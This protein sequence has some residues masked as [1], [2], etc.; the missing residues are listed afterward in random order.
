MRI[1]ILA[2]IMLVAACAQGSISYSTGPITENTVIP[3]GSPLGVA[4][5]ENITAGASGIPANY[6]V[7]GLTVG[8]DISGGYNGGLVAYLVA[9][10]GMMVY[11]VN[12]PGVSGGNPFG[13]PGSGMDVTLQD[14]S[15]SIQSVSETAGT[16]L[17]GT[18]GA[19]GSLS[20][21]N[22]SAADGNWTLF[23]ANLSGGGANGELLNFTLDLT[24][25]PE[26]VGMALGVFGGLLTL[27][28]FLGRCWKRPEGMTD[29]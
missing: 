26:P 13:A 18:Y 24:A 27:W 5:T 28:W 21:V 23:F 17:T 15:T 25:V 14:G 12:Q 2:G 11:L 6:V 20:G 4:V 16:Q 8:L 22:G 3:N 9:P 1:H 19:A 10:N 29:P 7:S